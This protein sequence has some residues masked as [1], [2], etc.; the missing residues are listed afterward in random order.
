MNT[1]ANVCVKFSGGRAEPGAGY[2]TAD[3]LVDGA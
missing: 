3:V 2:A 1:A